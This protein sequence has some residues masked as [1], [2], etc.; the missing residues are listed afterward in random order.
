MPFV[1]V[2]PAIF[3]QFSKVRHSAGRHLLH[4]YAAEDAHCLR[5]VCST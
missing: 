2:L 3:E 5:C 1:T 4:V